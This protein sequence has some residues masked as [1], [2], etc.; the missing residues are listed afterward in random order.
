MLLVPLTAMLDWMRNAHR[1]GLR[2]GGEDAGSRL[3]TAGQNL[4]V[5]WSSSCAVQLRPQDPNSVITGGQL[6]GQVRLNAQ[7]NIFVGLP[8][9]TWHHHNMALGVAFYSCSLGKATYGV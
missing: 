1:M 5:T 8:S 6:A 3:R 4:T 2:A 9:I 7:L